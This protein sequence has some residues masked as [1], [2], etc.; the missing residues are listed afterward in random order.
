M[1]LKHSR[2]VGWSRG[3][4]GGPLAFALAH[5]A[6]LL[7]LRAILA[8]S[9]RYARQHSLREIACV[10]FGGKHRIVL[11][12]DC[13]ERLIVSRQFCL[14]IAYS[15]AERRHGQTAAQIERRINALETGQT[16]LRVIQH[17]G[18]SSSSWHKV[19]SF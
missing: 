7:I 14:A 15:V 18:N 2:L 6:G 13:R 19:F 9:S 10:L 17:L 16:G 3:F 1:R 12:V 8:E 5:S 11:I 4:P